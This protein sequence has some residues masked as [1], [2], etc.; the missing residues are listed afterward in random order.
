MKGTLLKISEQNSFVVIRFEILLRPSRCENVFWSFEERVHMHN[1][2][3]HTVCSS[4]ICGLS[5]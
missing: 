4:E 3:R 5:G 1:C 2:T